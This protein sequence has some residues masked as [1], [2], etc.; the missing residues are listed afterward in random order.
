MQG[1]SQ[2]DDSGGYRSANERINSTGLE[3]SQR[4][5]E[6]LA[7]YAGKSQEPIGNARVAGRGP[8]AFQLVS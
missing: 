1:Y 5:V 8:H 6:R 7:A 2:E 3:I 4:S